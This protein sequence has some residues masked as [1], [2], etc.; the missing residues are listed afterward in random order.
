MGDGR[1]LPFGVPLNKPA[2][3]FDSVTR[4]A[5]KSSSR[6]RTA[7]LV[8]HVGSPNV[9]IGKHTEVGAQ[10]DVAVV[11]ESREEFPPPLR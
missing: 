3:P 7:P 10:V 8:G 6:K 11:P 5:A 4:Y 1:S 9:S 2:R